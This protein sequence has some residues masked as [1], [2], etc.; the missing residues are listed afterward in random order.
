M[1]EKVTAGFRGKK[2]GTHADSGSQFHSKEN[3]IP[4]SIYSGKVKTRKATP[5]TDNHVEGKK[6]NPLPNRATA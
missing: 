6:M 5:L 3:F 2:N 1:N 4:K